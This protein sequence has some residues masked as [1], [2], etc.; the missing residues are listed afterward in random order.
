MGLYDTISRVVGSSKAPKSVRAYIIPISNETG[1][2]EDESSIRCFQ[3]FPETISDSRQS[4]WTPKDIPGLSHPLYQWVSGGPRE[5]S[6]TA[7][8]SRDTDV[9][10][11]VSSASVTDR[12]VGA[13][14]LYS[15]SNT[16]QSG[17]ID[18][19]RNVDIPGAVAWL[20]QFTYPIYINNGTP[21]D[22]ALPPKRLVLVMP[23]VRLNHSNPGFGASEVPCIMTQCDVTYEAFF[24]SGTPRLA[25]VALTFAEVIQIQNTIKPQDGS[26]VRYIGQSMYRFKP[27]DKKV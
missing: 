6:F 9:N 10:I 4:N 24:P 5:I 18:N 2:M 23:G 3:Y 17:Q 7:I 11:N 21:V 15:D 25:K 14:D 27:N 8:F 16:V 22:R 12:F 1:N 19:F 20:R 26:V 13:T